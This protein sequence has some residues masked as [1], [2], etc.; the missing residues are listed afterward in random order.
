MNPKPPR[1]R[2]CYDFL[3]SGQF[4]LTGWWTLCYPAQHLYN[5]I[6]SLRIHQIVKGNFPFPSPAQ[7][8]NCIYGSVPND[9]L[10]KGVKGVLDMHFVGFIFGRGNFPFLIIVWG[11]SAPCCRPLIAYQ[12]RRA[13]LS[14]AVRMRRSSWPLTGSAGF[15]ISERYKVPQWEDTYSKGIISA[16]VLQTQL[17]FLYNSA[18]QPLQIAQ[19]RLLQR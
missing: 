13:R 15:A 18:Y 5:G 2:K 14:T 17:L 7:L 12:Q 3:N 16:I 11:G 1:L 9:N 4:L 10:A 19:K 6:H 8:Q